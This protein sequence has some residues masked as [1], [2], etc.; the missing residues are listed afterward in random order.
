MCSAGSIPADSCFFINLQAGSACL[1]LSAISVLSS[2]RT[3][4]LGAFSFE[5]PYKP[6]PEHIQCLKL[7][8]YST[9]HILLMHPSLLNFPILAMDKSLLLKLTATVTIGW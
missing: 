8:L 1:E 7:G 2:C 4:R 9:H 5:T 3:D 6:V